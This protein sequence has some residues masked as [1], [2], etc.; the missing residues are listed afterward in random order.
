MKRL[1]EVLASLLLFLCFGALI[2]ALV[3]VLPAR[4]PKTELHKF[5]YVI[6]VDSTGM[7]SDMARRQADSLI[8]AVKHHERQIAQHYDYVLQQ[9][10]DSQTWLSFGGIVLSIVISVFGFFGFKNYK[11]IEEKAVEVAEDAAGKMAQSTFNEY[12]E[13]TTNAM[14]KRIKTLFF[15]ETHKQEKTLRTV[16]DEQIRIKYS[17]NTLCK[18]DDIVSYSESVEELKRTISQLQKRIDD[19]ETKVQKNKEN[20]RRILRPSLAQQNPNTNPENKV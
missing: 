7:M 19:I 3:C 14:K 12:K 16:I 10:E 11:S 1:N 8:I 5:Q 18:K 4:M 20:K 17:D 2:Y 13:D 6:T 9:Q 15:N